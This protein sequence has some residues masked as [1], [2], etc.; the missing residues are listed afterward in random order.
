MIRPLLLAASAALTLA[1]AL[2][3]AARAQD[4]AVAPAF[5]GLTPESVRDWLSTA[6]AQVGEVTRDGE[7]VFFR[8]DDAGLVWFVF[9]YGCEADGRC[10]DVQF[11]A[12]FEGQGVTVEEVNAWNREQRF[13]KAFLTQ[14]EGQPVVFMQFDVLLTSGL[15]VEQMADPTIVWLEGLTRASTFL[16]GVGTAPAS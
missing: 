1:V 15:P 4:A 7:D 2:P 16:D 8:V 5:V 9:F 11:N 10:G 3:G 13:L 12:V 6:G 14:A